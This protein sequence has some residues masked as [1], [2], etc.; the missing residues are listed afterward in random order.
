MLNSVC[1]CVLFCVFKANIAHV[2]VFHT[3]INGEPA[4]LT[5]PCVCE[6]DEQHHLT[7]CIEGKQT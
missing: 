1:V 5:C 7:G 3:K 6:A 2:L 4:L